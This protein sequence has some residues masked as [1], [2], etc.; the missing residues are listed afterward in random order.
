MSH[1]ELP[2]IYGAEPD[3]SPHAGQSTHA[4]RKAGGRG[5]RQ[6]HLGNL[7]DGIANIFTP[8]TLAL[9]ISTDLVGCVH[10]TGSHANDDE[11]QDELQGQNSS[12]ATALRRLPQ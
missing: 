6:V 7:L 10:A 3:S 11:G 8:D 4:G 2:P 1:P 9:C 5:S 12:R